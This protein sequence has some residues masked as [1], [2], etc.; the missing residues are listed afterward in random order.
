MVFSH[1]LGGSHQTL[2]LLRPICNV[3]STLVQ[4]EDDVRPAKSSK[5]KKQPVK[6]TKRKSAARDDNQT[7]D[8][9]LSEDQDGLTTAKKARKST[10]KR[11]KKAS[12]TGTKSKAGGS[13]TKAKNGKGK[14][15]LVKDGDMEISDDNGLF[16]E[17]R[18]VR[19]QVDVERGL[20]KRHLARDHRRPPQPRHPDRSGTRG[21][22]DRVSGYRRRR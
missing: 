8:E 2:P 22:V 16:S 3:R 14:A 12:T 13:K 7:D 1:R 21:M 17:C 11:T 5:T 18:S 15:V 4:S 10:G 9:E 20:T 6:K 19:K